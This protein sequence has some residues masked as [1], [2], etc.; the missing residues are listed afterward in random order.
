MLITMVSGKAAPGVSTSTWALSIAWPGP[1]LAVD[2]DPAG[3]DLSAGLL[4]GRGQVD[5]GVLSWSTAARRAPAVEAAAMIAGHVVA[6]PEAPQVWLMPGF[7]TAAQAAA[8][9]AGGWDRMAAALHREASTGRDVLVDTGRLGDGSCWPVIGSA[10]RVVLVCRRSGRSIHAAGN[11]AGLLRARL[12]DL[13]SVV[14]LVVDDAGPYD[15]TSIARELGVTL[16]GELPA[17]RAAAA[18][19]SDAGPAGLRGLARSKLIRR[20]RPVAA[21]LAQAPRAVTGAQVGAPR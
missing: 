18:A 16:L 17:D 4:L 3:G 20:A 19:L 5:H 13:G 9:D 15:A 10:Q 12:G 6:L 14:L 21:H 2:A 1:V 8:M 7:Q 11:A